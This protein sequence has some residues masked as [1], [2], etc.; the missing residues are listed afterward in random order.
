MLD[1]DTKTNIL[2]EQ[3]TEPKC[4]VFG[5]CGGCLY[6]DVSYEKELDIKER[7]LK[8]YLK[9]ELS[10]SEEI[11]SPIEASPKEYH[12]RSRLDLTLRRYRDGEIEMGFQL[13]ESKRLV[14]INECAIS[15]ESISD[16]LPTLNQEASKKLP[17][18]YKTANLV[19]KTGDDGRI[20]WGG[21]GKGSLKMTEEDYL[22]TEIKGQKIYYSLDTFFQANLSILPRL[23]ATIESLVPK[24]AQHIFLD[25]YSGVGLFGLP[26]A[27][28]FRKVVMIEENPA[29]TRIAD[30]NIRKQGLDNVEIHSGRVEDYLEEVLIH[31]KSEK[32]V[33]MI[34]PPR[35]GLSASVAQALVG[36]RGLHRLFYL[37]CHPESLV[38]DLK[39]FMD[40]NWEVLNVIPFDFFPKTKHLE[41]L[42]L[43]RPGVVNES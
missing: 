27:S 41:T 9:D 15:M 17:A 35:R 16:F 31:L 34:D 22:W 19:V 38:R 28:R 43:L 14:A 36:A 1:Q 23:I 5:Q 6:Q 33:A 29:S 21:I 37:S 4:A 24:E 10:I 26:L 30:Y 2:R 20:C 18:K 25:L 13:P 40:A 39:F 3:R 32:P 8:Q 12:S 7:Y 11:I 42:V